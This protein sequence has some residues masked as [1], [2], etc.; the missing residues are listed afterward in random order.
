MNHSCYIIS[1]GFT[2]TAPALASSAAAA[3][4]RASPPPL[5]GPAWRWETWC[6]FRQLFFL[7]KGAKFNNVFSRSVLDLRA[8]LRQRVQLLRLP[9]G[10]RQRPQGQE[11]A[12]WVT[13]K[14]IKP[15]KSTEVSWAV[16]IFQRTA[17]A[18][19]NL[20][21]L[22]RSTSNFQ[23]V[24]CMGVPKLRKSPLLF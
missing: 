6:G 20:A 9:A 15:E 3:A 22:R 14:K 23:Y 2:T 8:R 7:K 24:F 11:D 10:S 18:G 16:R 1:A 4:A 17:K 5:R 12:L 13:E 19:N 21:C